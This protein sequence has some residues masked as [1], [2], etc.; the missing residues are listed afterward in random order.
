M[1]QPEKQFI[2]FMF[3]QEIYYTDAKLVNNMIK[4][5]NSII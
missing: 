4:L 3:Q 2:C 5:G 1:L